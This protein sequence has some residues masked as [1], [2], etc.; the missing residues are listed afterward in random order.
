RRIFRHGGR[1]S[2]AWSSESKW[3]SSTSA[4]SFASVRLLCHL[5]QI[6]PPTIGKMPGG[7]YW[8]PVYN[9]LEGDVTVFLVHAAHVTQVPGRKTDKADAR[10]LATLR[11]DGLL[12]AS[13]IPPLEQ[14]DWRDLTRD[15][16]K[17]AGSDARPPPA[18]AK[19]PS[20]GQSGAR[21]A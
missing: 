5:L 9:S 1:S 21:A 8:K 16:T 19:G 12:Q 14:R 10:W 6:V 3:I 2:V 20:G 17:L 13:C 18:G 4:L 7:E 11:R 15:R